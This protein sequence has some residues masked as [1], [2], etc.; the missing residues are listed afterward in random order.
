MT[1]KIDGPSLTPKTQVI[2]GGGAA[3]ADGIVLVK[4]IGNDWK[5]GVSPDYALY[6]W[7]VAGSTPVELDVAGKLTS[8]AD[9]ASGWR[10]TYINDYVWIEMEIASLEVVSAAVANYAG[11]GEFGGGEVEHDGNG[12]QTKARKVLAQ[13]I[14]DGT[15]GL[16]V[17]TFSGG[18]HRV[19]I[20]VADAADSG[21][22]NAIPGQTAVLVEAM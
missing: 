5:V 20:G 1:S 3:A 18:A 7:I 10:D 21:G 8:T 17:R 2:G 22:G 12:S 11:G 9:D 6:Q 4:K 13:V 14:S 15:G 16:A 19:G